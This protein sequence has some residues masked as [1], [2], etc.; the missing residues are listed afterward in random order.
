MRGGKINYKMQSMILLR[1]ND[2]L[3]EKN[4]RKIRN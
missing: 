3:T 2:Q 1:I 4:A